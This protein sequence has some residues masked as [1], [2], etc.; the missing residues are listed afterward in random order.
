MIKT[1]ISIRKGSKAGVVFGVALFSPLVLLVLLILF[2]ILIF[3]L[4]LL[5]FVW[6]L[7]QR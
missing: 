5:F 3:M 2:L 1:K 4:L 6:A 7:T